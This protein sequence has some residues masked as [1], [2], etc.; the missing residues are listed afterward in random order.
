MSTALPLHGRTVLV[1]GA[2]RGIG[3]AVARRLAASGARVAL[4][5]RRKDT[6]RKLA[7]EIGHGAVGIACD[8]RDTATLARAIDQLPD[9]IGGAPEIVVN[10]AGAFFIAAAQDTSVEAFAETLAVNLTAPFAVVRSLMPAMRDAGRGHIVNIGSIADR[11]TFPGNA[12]YASSK[13]GLRA[14][15]QVLRDEL[16]GSGIRVSLVSPGPVDTDLWNPVDPDHR[17]GFTPRA[18]MLS[19]EAVADA[20]HYVVTAAPDLNVDELRL[21][22]S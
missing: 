3:A 7:E 13:F 11:A 12:A 8:V 10:N 1:T 15:H 18:A 19:A 2:S 21:S 20:V 6:L 17:E 22:R 4:L 9:L 14:M 5:A 16:R